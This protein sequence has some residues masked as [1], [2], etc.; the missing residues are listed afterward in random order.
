[1]YIFRYIQV[2]DIDLTFF[3]WTTSKGSLSIEDNET[4]ASY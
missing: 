4:V 3:F 2:Q 1:M